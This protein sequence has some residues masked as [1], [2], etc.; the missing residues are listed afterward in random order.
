ML[1]TISGHRTHFTECVSHLVQ[2][3]IKLPFPAS[4]RAILK[5]KPPEDRMRDGTREHSTMALAATDLAPGVH[6]TN[7]NLLTTTKGERIVKVVLPGSRFIPC[8]LGVAKEHPQKMTRARH[9]RLA[10]RCTSMHDAQVVDELNV[11]LLAIKFGA[12]LLGRF[13]HCV[14]SMHLLLGKIRHAWV[15]R[16]VKTTQ[17][18]RFN[19]LAHRLALREEQSW[20]EL[21]V[22][23]CVSGILSA[24]YFEL[25]V[26][27]LLLLEL[28]RPLGLRHRFKHSR[29]LFQEFVV[30]A[31][32]R[33][34]ILLTSIASAA[35]IPHMH[36]EDVAGE[37]VVVEVH[38][39]RNFRASKTNIFGPT[40]NLTE[41]CVEY[42]AC[43]LS[44]CDILHTGPRTYLVSGL[45]MS[46]WHAEGRY[47]HR[48]RQRQ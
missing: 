19:K 42:V 9:V 23:I 16:N 30:D 4:I 31:P 15:T 8:T 46:L 43:S 6:V 21:Q 25:R 13:L 22:R 10:I 24:A 29:V 48:C 45:R 5:T 34:K 41:S 47:V 18:R 17:K 44:V 7:R 39:G 11:A 14:D 28:E 37:P 32:E 33:S 1:H 26:R 20:T 2:A 38:L 40:R 3:K 36:G 27:H 35:I 12:D